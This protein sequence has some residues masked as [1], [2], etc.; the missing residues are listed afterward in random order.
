MFDPFHVLV[1]AST[2]ELPK[3]ALATKPRSVH[4]LLDCLFVFLQL[5]RTGNFGVCV[6]LKDKK[7]LYAVIS[8]KSHH[9]QDMAKG[10]QCSVASNNQ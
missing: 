4:V 3:V 2:R 1:R 6:E 7:G 5:K 10:H 9:Y 8:S